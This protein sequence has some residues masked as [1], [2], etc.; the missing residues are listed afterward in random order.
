RLRA[1]AFI[2]DTSDT[3]VGRR[4]RCLTSALAGTCTRLRTRTRT[5][6]AATAASAAASGTASTNESSGSWPAEPESWGN[7]DE[8]ASEPGHRCDQRCADR[9]TRVVPHRP[10]LPGARRTFRPGHVPGIEDRAPPGGDPRRERSPGSQ[11]QGEPVSNAQDDF[12]DMFHAAFGGGETMRVLKRLGLENDPRFVENPAQHGG[13][14]DAQPEH[15]PMPAIDP[16]QGRG[17]YGV[18]NEPDPAKRA[19]KKALFP[20]THR[21]EPPH[22][23]D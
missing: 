20:I 22:V 3:S 12:R 6:A 21:H 8:E 10:W 15:L 7:C 13:R 1:G 23:R 11:Q 19:F 9:R 5:T 14:A 4:S 17:R 2:C 18:S 16:S